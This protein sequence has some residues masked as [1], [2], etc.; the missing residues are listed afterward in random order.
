MIDSQKKKIFILLTFAKKHNEKVID[1]SSIDIELQ[2]VRIR[3]TGKIGD[4]L[5]N[6]GMHLNGFY[7][8]ISC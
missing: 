1:L 7:L 8:I 5:S 2:V 6:V 4:R 3:S